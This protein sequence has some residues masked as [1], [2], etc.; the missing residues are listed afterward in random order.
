MNEL[1]REVAR[2]E[3]MVIE[4]LTPVEQY[5][6]LC[7]NEGFKMHMCKEEKKMLLYQSD[8]YYLQDQIHNTMYLGQIE[9]DIE[10]DD[11]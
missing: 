10:D 11:E 5:M 2:K 8:R 1:Y 7:G 4:E 6:M 9:D 3:P